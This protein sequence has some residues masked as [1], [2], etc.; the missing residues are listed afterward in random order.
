MARV[1]C[2]IR[3]CESIVA[4]GC[5]RERERE[6]SETLG[7]GGPNSKLTNF[8]N[9]VGAMKEND[10]RQGVDSETISLSSASYLSRPTINPRSLLQ[11]GDRRAQTIEG[12]FKLL[13]TFSAPVWQRATFRLAKY[14]RLS[15]DGD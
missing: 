6:T 10:I 12:Y 2:D 3:D 5:V 13:S 1:L 15:E 14:S 7:R 11:L 4:P 9:I 8:T